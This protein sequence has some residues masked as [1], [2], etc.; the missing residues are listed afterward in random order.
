MILSDNVPKYL[1]TVFFQEGPLDS[2]VFDRNLVVSEPLA[3]DIIQE[4]ATYFAKTGFRNFDRPVLGYVTPWNNHGYDIA[5]NF[6]AKFTHI[7]P[8][9]LQ[10]KRRD[11]NKY[12]ITGTHDI[13]RKWL[14]EVRKGNP[15]IRIDVR[16][17]F[18]GWTIQDF[19]ALF[20]KIREQEALAKAVTDVCL[21]YKFDGIVLELWSQVGG[22][23]HSEIL[24]DF[25]KLVAKILEAKSLD[26]IL[27]VPPYR[28]G[29]TDVFSSS[30]FDAL[31][32]SVTGFSLM[33]YDFS[34]LQRPG[35]NS[36]LPWVRE[37]VKR[38]V[39]E[40]GKRREKIWLGLN[41]Y[42]NDY[43]TSGGG[44]ILGRDMLG[45]LK[46]YKGK[47]KFDDAS[48]ENFFEVR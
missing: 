20:S 6:S 2:S 43:T 4:H 36:P 17:F 9:W 24:V 16:I 26:L 32:K 19:T 23:V 47:L 18:D 29:E 38:L 48:V 34:S 21:T 46:D 42:G 15:K 12:E 37:C 13:D 41:F 3:K 40:D 28:G 45:L 33:T 1:P 25:V 7:S 30:N 35:P 39:P 44:P 31:Y 22:S 10:V 5:K 14:G 8:V 27:V 11:V